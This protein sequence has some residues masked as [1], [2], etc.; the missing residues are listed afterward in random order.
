MPGAPPP[1][2]I[3]R[4]REFSV[5]IQIFLFWENW[6]WYLDRHLQSFHHFSWHWDK[7]LSS[8][9]QYFTF[10]LM[11]Q[12]YTSSPDW[13]LPDGSSMGKHTGK[14]GLSHDDDTRTKSSK[15]FIKTEIFF[16]EVIKMISER[17]EFPQLSENSLLNLARPAPG[18]RSRTR[19]SGLARALAYTEVR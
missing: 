16:I 5:S 9:Q 3:P 15:L 12:D 14:R 1:H 19:H 2:L 8:Q 6:D 10:Y 7:V 11:S 4:E 17:A 18:S 13:Q